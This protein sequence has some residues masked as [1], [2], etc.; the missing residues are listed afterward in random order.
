MRLRRLT[1]EMKRHLLFLLLTLPITVFAQDSITLDSHNT[2][3]GTFVARKQIRLA[4]GFSFKATAASTLRAYISG[5]YIITVTPLDATPEARFE[6][7]KLEIRENARALVNIQYYDGL[8]RPVEHVQVGVTPV[9]GDLATWQDYDAF[10]RPDKTWLPANAYTENYGAFLPPA[11]YKDRSASTYSSDE[12]P[13]SYPVYEASPLGRVVEQYGPGR[14][15][16]QGGK[17]VKTSQVSFDFNVPRFTTVNA[18]NTVSITRSSVYDFGRLYVEE[19]IDEDGNK[20]YTATDS[21][22]RMVYTRQMDG[23]TPVETSY[24][25]DGFGNLRA[26]LPPLAVFASGTRGES[27]QMLRD[28]AYLYKYDS[29]NRCIAKKLPGAEWIYYVYDN[30]DRLIFTQDGELRKRGEWLFSIPDALGR[31]V[32]TGVCKNTLKAFRICR[33]SQP[34]ITMTTTSQ[35]RIPTCSIARNRATTPATRRATRDCLPACA[36]PS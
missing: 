7:G 17:P 35:H 6:D 25:Y 26:V 16:Q 13:Y 9:F 2:T 10:G 11:K 28:Y 33:Y 8:G 22:G 32:L 15:W 24:I 14:S 19:T 34:P 31:V 3:G 30:A 20:S 29:R 21:Q 36:P 12:K 1:V 18:R 23:E 4:P 5:N 27:D